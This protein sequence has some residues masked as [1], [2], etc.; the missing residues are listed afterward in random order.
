MPTLREK[1]RHLPGTVAS[2]KAQ[3]LKETGE[4]RV[5][6]LAHASNQDSVSTSLNERES[7]VSERRGEK[8][9]GGRR[10]S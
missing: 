4:S 3:Y 8:R 10:P 7:G 9:G 6:G 2:L 1:E 5:Q